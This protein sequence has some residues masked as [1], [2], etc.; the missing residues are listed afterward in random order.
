GVQRDLRAATLVFGPRS[1]TRGA[2][3]A[4]RLFQRLVRILCGRF[5]SKSNQP[6]RLDT[7]HPRNR[8][9]VGCDS[10]IRHGGDSYRS[11]IV[12]RHRTLSQS[13]RRLVVER[14][15]AIPRSY[16]VQ[17]VSDALAHWWSLREFVGTSCWES[18]LAAV[19]SGL[20]G[21]GHRDRLCQRFLAPDRE[22]EYSA[23]SANITTRTS[24]ADCPLWRPTNISTIV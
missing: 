1:E 2:C 17:F 5:R 7:F 18:T 14:T 24:D 16:L 20:R 23:Q 4:G 13:P 10:W 12:D 19:G 9:V 11:R 3:P 21:G 22:T 8:C 6:T 15:D